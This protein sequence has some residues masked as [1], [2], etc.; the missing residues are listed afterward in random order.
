MVLQPSI[1]SKLL[2]AHE[3]STESLGIGELSPKVEVVGIDG[4]PM[5]RKNIIL[6]GKVEETA[7]ELAEILAK[8]GIF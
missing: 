3:W 8:E 7:T 2:E 1:I 5:E 4:V 6:E